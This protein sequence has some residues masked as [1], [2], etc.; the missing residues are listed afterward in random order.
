MARR[1]RAINPRSPFDHVEVQLQDAP[2]AQDPFGHWDKCELG[3]LAQDRAAGSEEQVFYQLLRKRRPAADPP[4]LQ[5][6]FS[7]YFHRVPVESVM[8]VEARVFGGNHSMLQIGGDF[9]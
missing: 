2:L 9:A 5:V 1:F 8:F 4:A 7:S 6:P 3:A